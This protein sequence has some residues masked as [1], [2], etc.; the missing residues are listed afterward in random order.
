[1][2][3]FL[4]VL[5]LICLIA[6]PSMAD[7]TESGSVVIEEPEPTIEYIFKDVNLAKLG[8]FVDLR[9]AL[10]KA[11]DMVA[12]AARIVNSEKTNVNE[13]YVACRAELPADMVETFEVRLAQFEILVQGLT[14]AV[15]LLTADYSEYN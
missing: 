8:R 4:S 13:K 1:M 9:T 6:T 2:R 7:L 15:D 11:K 12:N 5:C 14:D 3:K 10:L